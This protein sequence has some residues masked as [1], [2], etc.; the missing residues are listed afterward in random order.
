MWKAGDTVGGKGAVYIPSKKAAH[1]VIFMH[2]LGDTC[3]GWAAT[4]QG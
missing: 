4:L 1:A 2:G 3:D